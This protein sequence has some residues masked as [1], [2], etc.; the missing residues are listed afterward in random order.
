MPSPMSA[1]S[2]ATTPESV[3]GPDG[4]GWDGG[5]WDGDGWDGGGWDG[6]GSV[7]A[8]GGLAP[9]LLSPPPPP[10]PQAQRINADEASIAASARMHL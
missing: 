5:C 4:D 3:T 10:P 7:G 1:L 9:L 8:G 2:A 6:D